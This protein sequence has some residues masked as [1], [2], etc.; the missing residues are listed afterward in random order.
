MVPT[1]CIIV[2]C[3]ADMADMGVNIVRVHIL[4]CSRDIYTLAVSIAPLQGEGIALREMKEFSTPSTPLP[5]ST[6]DV[7]HLGGAQSLGQIG[8]D[9]FVGCLDRVIVNNAQISL[10]LPDEVNH[11]LSTCSPRYDTIVNLKIFYYFAYCTGHQLSCQESLKMGCGYRNRPVLFLLISPH[12]CHPLLNLF[13][14]MFLSVLLH[15]MAS[16]PISPISPPHT[17][18]CCTSVTDE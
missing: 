6:D 10:L 14:L 1:V 5:L 2:S 4:C 18:C 7:I 17:I 8:L 16:S 13:K 15:M 11:S 9:S 3:I 12:N